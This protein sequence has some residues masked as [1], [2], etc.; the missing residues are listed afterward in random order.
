MEEAE[1][2]LPSWRCL[3]GSKNKNA[4][5]GWPLRV[6]VATT[7]TWVERWRWWMK[8]DVLRKAGPTGDGESERN[9]PLAMALWRLARLLPFL[10]AG[11]RRVVAC[12]P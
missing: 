2:G 5:R 3:I 8:M 10:A 4:L 1:R 6:M 11:G 9:E 7:A 12:S